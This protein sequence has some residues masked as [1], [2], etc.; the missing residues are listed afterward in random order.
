MRCLGKD[1]PTVPALLEARLR[2]ALCW[3]C[4]G[5]L[6]GTWEGEACA[7]ESQN[8][9]RN[10]SNKLPWVQHFISRS[11]GSGQTKRMKTKT[12]SSSP[13]QWG[14]R[15]SVPAGPQ[16]AVAG[17]S[18]VPA[19]PQGRGWG[20]PAQRKKD[21]R[22]SSAHGYQGHCVRVA[23]SGHG[24]GRVGSWAGSWTSFG[25]LG[26]DPQ[27]GDSHLFSQVSMSDC[28]NTLNVFSMPGPF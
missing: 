18:S 12:G 27:L 19:G 6:Q 7:T 14:A 21:P 23:S 1:A 15:S 20:N 16:G 3:L 25:V 17:P 28:E 9:T 22:Y 5:Y 11:A 8:G 24:Q 10:Q 4:I 2:W 13:T 26:C